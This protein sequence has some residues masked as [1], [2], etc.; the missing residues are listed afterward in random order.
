M[1]AVEVS[2]DTFFGAG[3]VDTENVDTEAVTGRTEI[4]L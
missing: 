1:G 4:E 2:V 3:I